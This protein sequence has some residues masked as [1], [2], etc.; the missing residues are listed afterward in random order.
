MDWPTDDFLETSKSVG[1]QLESAE[2]QGQNRGNE[3]LVANRK[4]RDEEKFKR[5]EHQLQVSKVFVLSYF[6]QSQ[7]NFIDLFL[8]SSTQAINKI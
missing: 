6:H 1:G 4:S 7:N 5:E 2:K 8:L 3:T